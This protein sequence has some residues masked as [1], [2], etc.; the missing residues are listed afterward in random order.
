MKVGGYRRP[1]LLLSPVL[2]VS[3]FPPENLAYPAAYSAWHQVGIVILQGDSPLDSP[4]D[5]VIPKA[6]HTHNV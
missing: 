5:V 1:Q 2:S 3:P 6:Q 4:V